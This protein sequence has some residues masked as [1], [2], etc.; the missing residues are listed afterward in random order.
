MVE[1]IGEFWCLYMDIGVWSIIVVI[2][3]D[4]CYVFG[5][6]LFVNNIYEVVCCMVVN[7]VF[8]VCFDKFCGWIV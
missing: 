3:F 4:I 1:R 8:S 7:F 2:N 5:D 6:F